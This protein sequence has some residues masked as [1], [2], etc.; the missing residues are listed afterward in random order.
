MEMYARVAIAGVLCPVSRCEL[1]FRQPYRGASGYGTTSDYRR[2]SAADGHAC[3]I[4]WPPSTRYVEHMSR[5]EWTTYRA[6]K[7]FEVNGNLTSKI[8]QS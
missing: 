2:L 7:I 3:M 6:E 5:R 1:E 4:A 8:P